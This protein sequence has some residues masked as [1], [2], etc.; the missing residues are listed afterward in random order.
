MIA[1]ISLL[2]KEKVM[3]RSV[4][5]QLLSFVFCLMTA[6]IYCESA[7]ADEV[8]FEILHIDVGWQDMIISGNNYYK[9]NHGL[10]TTISRGFTFFGL[11]GLQIDQ[12]LGFIS[13]RKK[14]EN[15]TNDIYFKGGTFL[16]LSIF[17]PTT[18]VTEDSILMVNGK[19]GLG[20]V[21]METPEYAEKSAQVWFAFRPSVSII[22]MNLNSLK[23]PFFGGGFEFDYTLAASDPN[24]FDH[25]R[26]SHFL[27]LKA[28]FVAC[29]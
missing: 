13:L 26:L 1:L 11:F 27:G 17:V 3:F 15:Q 10:S 18:T 12:E 28:V 25:K 9:N 2:L 20:L 7:Y 24:V 8:P 23:S 5:T 21:Y 19:L 6:F 14:G 29:F 22:F 16:N 4:Q